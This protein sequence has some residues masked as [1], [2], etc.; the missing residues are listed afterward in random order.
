VLDRLQGAIWFS[1]LDLKAGYWQI[2]MDEQDAEKTAFTNPQGGLYH[3]N[4]LSFGLCNAPATFCRLIDV[5]LSGLNWKECMVY[6][7]DIVVFSKTWEQHL[8]SL[9]AI[10]DRLRAAGLKLHAKKCE[11][12]RNEIKYLGHVVNGEGIKPDPKKVAALTSLSVPRTVKEVQQFLG[13]LGYYRKFV[14]GFAERASPLYSL[15]KKGVPFQWTEAHQQAFMDLKDALSENALLHLP[16][17]NRPFVLKTDASGFAISAIL[18]QFD[19]EKRERPVAYASRRLSAAERK[20]SASERECIAL[21]WG[22]KSFN[23]YLYG[24]RFFVVTDHAALT[25]LRQMRDTNAKLMRWSLQLQEYD[26]DVI[27]KKGKLHVDADALSRL[28]P[29]EPLPGTL[30]PVAHMSAAATE[31]VHALPAPTARKKAGQPANVS[32][33]AVPCVP[34]G[35]A[36]QRR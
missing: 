7:D 16:D 23:T 20:W 34:Q 28:F 33:C 1:S 26:M 21:V 13:L 27:H 5:V 12:A 18:I 8:R 17:L 3:F 32:P 31:A 19:E 25:Y 11:L 10:M 29:D 9:R 14:R 4:V 36:E 24:R 6:V 30:E 35:R 2:A 15:L 22:V